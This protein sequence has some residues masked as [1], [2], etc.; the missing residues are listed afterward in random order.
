MDPV[1]TTNGSIDLKPRAEV[2]G[3]PSR[4]DLD[5]DIALNIC[6]RLAEGRSMR[7]VCADPE[8]CIDH[9]VVYRRMA[10]HPDFAAAVFRARAAGCAHWYDEMLRLIDECTEANWQST[11]VKLWAISWVLGKMQPQRFGERVQQVFEGSITIDVAVARG[12]LLSKFDAIADRLAIAHES[13]LPIAAKA[14]VV[15]PPAA[16]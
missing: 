4:F 5:P 1:P 3:R 11:R 16:E 7:A 12:K 8:I 14:A 10:S 9:T 2:R 13:D 6:E 15:E